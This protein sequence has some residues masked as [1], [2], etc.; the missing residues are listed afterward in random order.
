MVARLPAPAT[1]RSSGGA[2]RF[3][4]LAQPGL[5]SPRDVRCA[6][7]GRTQE[8]EEATIGAR[9]KGASRKS[10]EDLAVNTPPQRETDELHPGQRTGLVKNQLRL[11]DQAFGTVFLGDKLNLHGTLLF[12]RIAQCRWERDPAHIQLT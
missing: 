3:V 6:A 2:P 5:D 8:I 1:A 10:N 11:A 7:L 4:L 9:A 12:L